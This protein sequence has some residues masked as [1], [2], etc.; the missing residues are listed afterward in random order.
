VGSNPVDVERTA[1]VLGLVLATID[2]RIVILQLQ[3]RHV[4]HRPGD[5]YATWFS[6]HLN[7]FGQVYTVA[8]DIVTGFVDDDLADMDADAEQQ[9]PLL[10]NAFIEARHALLDRDGCLDSGNRR[11]ELGE[12]RIARTVNHHAAG[13]FDGRLPDPRTGGPKV[14]ERQV[15]PP[16]DE[17]DETRNVSMQDRRQPPFGSRHGD[18][19]RERDCKGDQ[20]IRIDRYS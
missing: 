12:Y 15:F 9:P 8:K 6:Q 5:R 17:S 4:S 14:L 7:P 1:D 18:P 2:V 16:L 19:A 10:G 13:A 11:L 20:F 3:L